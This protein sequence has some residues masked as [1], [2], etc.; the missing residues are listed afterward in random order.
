MS[1]GH[2]YYWRPEIVWLHVT[3]DLLIALAYY[4]IPFALLYIVRR[5]KDLDY[6]WMFILFGVFI[7]A[8]GTTH[9]M[10]IWVVWEPV[11]RLDGVIKAITAIAS[12][13][14][15]ILLVR[16]AP[17]VIALPSPAQLREINASL[18]R[19]VL[20][21]K[22]VEA[23][24]RE[25]NIDLERRVQE[26]TRELAETNRKLRES[27]ARLQ[28]ILDTAPLPVFI[29][30]LEYRYLFGNKR[31]QRITG[32]SPNE[33]LGKTD[34][35]IWEEEAAN[36]FRAIDQ[37]VL[38]S[39]APVEA[40][41]VAFHDNENHHYASVK[42]PLFDE[43]QQAYAMCGMSADITEQKKSEQILKKYNAELE[44]FAYVAAHDLQEPLRTVKSYTQFLT[45][46]FANSADPDVVEFTGY[47]TSGIDRMVSLIAGLQ[48]Y[49]AVAHRPEHVSDAVDL[50]EVVQRT[51][52]NIR[53][54]ITESGARIHVGDLPTVPGSAL[55]LGLV[56]QNL[57][58]NAIKYRSNLPPEIS[59]T[60]TQKDRIV[61]VVVRD[62]GM[63]IDMQY[64]TKIFGV[65]K[66][67]HGFEYP[68]AG[69]GLAIVKKVIETHNGRIW[70]ESTTGEG[71]EFHFT[72]PV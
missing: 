34:Y 65:F 59:I 53:T 56:F 24:V 42:F 54:T 26:R 17:A 28:S 18:E 71:S 40:E 22:A 72:L 69:I 47:I 36:R 33:F 6:P 43:S 37:Q 60:C 49:T 10:S 63:G 46:K 57:I 13:P 9:L 50:S 35:D 14:T 58:T 25:L 21:R 15:A 30:D 1:H 55:Q 31:F 48:A 16:L 29:K 67:L 70:V 4:F 68:G 61:E 11:Y 32:K 51:L 7:L 64:S 23:E 62:N 2:C 20:E 44:Q 66:R 3:S 27:E 52:R 5:R 8:C 45:R 38:E 39:A 19:E 41:E 12:V